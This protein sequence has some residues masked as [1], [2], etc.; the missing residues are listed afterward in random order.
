MTKE[1]IFVSEIGVKLIEN[2]ADFLDSEEIVLMESIQGV[3]DPI[4]REK[5]E[6]HIR[7]AIAAL[8]EYE[9]TMILNS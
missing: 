2:I 5:S 8:C 9:K 3:K 4:P 1:R 7:M 6:L